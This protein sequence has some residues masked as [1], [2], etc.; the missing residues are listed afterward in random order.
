MARHNK[1]YQCIIGLAPRYLS[2][3][4][5]LEKRRRIRLVERGNGRKM[6]VLEK[7]NIKMANLHQIT[8]SL[9]RVN[10]KR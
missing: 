1:D 5:D 9:L 7:L 2:T 4:E 10:G 3:D 8:M 6:S